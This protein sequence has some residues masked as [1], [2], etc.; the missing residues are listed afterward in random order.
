MKIPMDPDAAVPV[1]SNTKCVSTSAVS[2]PPPPPAAAAGPEP[3]RASP[4]LLA[5]PAC[6][7]FTAVAIWQLV[8]QGLIDPDAPVSDYMDPADFNRTAPWCPRV[9]GAAPGSPCA[10]PTLRQLLS[11]GGGLVDI[12]NCKYA[13][14]AWQKEHCL[15]D[16]ET[17]LLINDSL[18]EG[19][20][21]GHGPAEYFAAEGYYDLPLEAEPGESC[22]RVWEAGAGAGGRGC[23]GL[24]RA[25]GG[26]A[27]L[28]AAGSARPAERLRRVPCVPPQTST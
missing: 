14:G 5:R 21:G 3:C 25:G 1:G 10:T 23:L 7:F 27:G 20:I 11:M 13:P 17:G 18:D 12:D 4:H 19:V 2:A 28:G 16:E 26:G 24:G 8:E 22:E 9:Y 6:R 15:R